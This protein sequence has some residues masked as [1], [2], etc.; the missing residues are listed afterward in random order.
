[1]E[2]RQLLRLL[3]Q[4]RRL[5]LRVFLVVFCGLALLTLLCETQYV[6]SAKVYIY[7]SSTKSSLLSRIMVDSA[8]MN[9][10]S[11]TDAERATY[12]DLAATTPVIAPVITELD[13]T[14]KRKSLQL[15]EFIPFMRA[16]IDH[17]LPD[18]GRRPMT[19]EELT[20]KSLVHMIFPRPYLSAEMMEDSDILE[21]S[22][23]ADSMALA[24]D[25]ANAAA[26]SFAV[27]ETAMRQDECRLL[28][29]GAARELPKARA[30]YEA[31]LA[32]LR[33]VR[34]REKIVDLDAEGE[35]LVQQY[36][37]LSADRDA[38]RLS[39]VKAR[40]MLDNVKIQLAKRPEFRKSSES[41]QRSGLID[42]VK[43]T[44]RDLYMD[45]AAAKARM[46]AEHPAVKEIEGKIEEAK[47]II[48]GESI[49]E[50][51][52]ETV[53]RDPV[54]SYLSERTAEYAA[55]V[56]GLESQDAAFTALLTEMEQKADTF[57][58]RV[59]AAAL[60]SARVEAG[61]AFLS[62]LNQLASMAKTGEGLDLSLSHLVEPATSPGKVE[63]YMRPKL[64][65]M[66]AVGLCL[67]AFLAVI[68]VLVAAYADETVSETA[69]LADVGVLP[70]A[71]VPGRPGVSR[72]Q[73]LRRFRDALF[74]VG[75]DAPRLAVL[76]GIGND[77][78]VPPAQADVPALAWGLALALARS[79]RSTLVVDADLTRPGLFALAGLPLG[80]GLAEAAAGEVPLESVIVPGPE[81]GLAVLPA[82]AGPLEADAADRRLDSPD[83]SALL[84]RLAEGYDAVLVC[85]APLSRRDDAVVL[86]RTADAVVLAVRLFTDSSAAVA[87]AAAAIEAASGRT[88]LAVLSGVPE[89][90]ATPAEVWTA[91]KRRL[92]LRRQPA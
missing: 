21:F 6:A 77:S 2:L 24:M 51:G 19:Y 73:G 66:L 70:V 43:L 35:Q 11:L 17:F 18:F 50:F 79:G 13:L 44:L 4:R 46:T 83:M 22:S 30:D 1:M 8:M 26:R 20:R 88:P 27:R 33:T 9:S 15:V 38:N 62:N 5:M 39:L 55:Q 10:A 58:G 31:A 65:L 74:P 32:E 61:Q 48:K 81:P 86:A 71:V 64:S 63:D 34:Q 53:A 7:H 16:V 42:A 90:D 52:S 76:A 40:G 91:L 37:A 68:A 28:A 89:D 78:A 14:R 29:E 41:I 82:G 67:G 72:A 69:A 45:L 36:Y 56:A 12:E 59:A 85:T 3:W 75:P 49:K 54:F 47:R 57:P 84:S 92:P 23:S 87:A 25:L 60:V 80:P